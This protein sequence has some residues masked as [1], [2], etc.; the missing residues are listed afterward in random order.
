MIDGWEIDFCSL[1]VFC[2][3]FLRIL[4]AR[5]GDNNECSISSVSI[6]FRVEF[7]SESDFVTVVWIVILNDLSF[8]MT[9]GK[10]NGLTR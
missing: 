10:L 4:L 9:E 8:R 2:R 1:C 3:E 5:S 7:K 6:D